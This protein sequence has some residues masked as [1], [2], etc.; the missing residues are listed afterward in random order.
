M[1]GTK[2]HQQ[3]FKIL[4]AIK[5]LEIISLCSP[6]LNKQI[7]RL[8]EEQQIWPSSILPLWQ[9]DP[10]TTSTIISIL[11]LIM[12]ALGQPQ[13]RISKIRST[14]CPNSRSSVRLTA[15]PVNSNLLHWWQLKWRK[16]QD[17]GQ[18]HLSEEVKRIQARGQLRC[19]KSWVVIR[20][21]FNLSN[22]LG[23]LKGRSYQ[24]KLRIK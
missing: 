18:S 6:K 13:L 24:G 7:L 5:L 9:V 11:T 23:I 10:D 20:A 1:D 4:P 14:L 8:I 19:K 15:N 16:E 17:L 21:K 22:S 3:T 12:P 2:T